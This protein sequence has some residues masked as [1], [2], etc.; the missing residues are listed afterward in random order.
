MN[1]VSI[2]DISNISGIKNVKIN[3]LILKYF[4][5]NDINKF[6]N[7]HKSQ[8]PVEFLEN[9]LSEF[10]IKI[11]ISENDIS[12][13]PKNGGFLTVSNHP[14]GG[15]DGIILL[16]ILLQQRSDF[17]ILANFLLEKITPISS[18]LITVNPFEYYNDNRNI[19][20]L[21][22]ALRLIKSDTPV[23]FFPAGEVSSF[24][25][26][27]KKVSDK[28]WDITTIRLIRG[29]KK[30]VVPI[31][32]R[33]S[34][35]LLFNTVGLVN[36]KLRTVT[37]GREFLKRKDTSVHVKI[38]KPISLQEQ[39]SFTTN[40]EYGRYLRARTYALGSDLN[41]NQFYF[42]K[43]FKLR[44]QEKIINPIK[45]ELILD[46]VNSLPREQLLFSI[47]DYEIYF[48]SANQIPNLIN[49]IGRLREM[50]FRKVGEGTNK[51]IDLDEFDLYF[52]QLFIWNKKDNELVGAYRI[53]EGD[54]IMNK[55]G[56]SGF[57][58]NQLFKIENEFNF[59]LERGIELGRSFVVE[60]YQKN[61]I[62][63]FTLW[64]G[65][66]YYLLKN[67]QYQFL[68]GPVSISNN[69]SKVSK[70]V[71]VDYIRDNHFDHELSK[72]VKPRKRF[73]YRRSS[74]MDYINFRNENITTVDNLVESIEPNHFKMPILLKKYIKQNGKFLGFN[75]DPKFSNSL[76]GFLLLD[77]NDI[78]QNTLTSLCKDLNDEKMLKRVNDLKRF[79]Y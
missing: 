50:T 26:E 16:Y 76:D 25:F 79:L 12:N 38:G 23:G 27:K 52:K 65:I 21:K 22:K 1:L 73:R 62:I 24:T 20:G 42:P 33:G 4:G 69:Y 8:K 9:L 44:K 58:M 53:G 61:P 45:Q 7:K 51:A 49:E 17:K 67:E 5:L 31:Y 74:D 55:F 34:N 37:L 46:N 57:Y 48:A 64:K 59:I 41:T 66:F 11:E 77:L 56:K 6:Y 60:K 39:N 36:P 63:L 71:M 19:S 47:K 28:R 75:L 54:Y 72:L 30:P 15:W 70:K 18:C 78:N 43:K 10:N 14:F 2:Q 32:F 35:S 3:Q 29:A 40:N 68:F 13:I